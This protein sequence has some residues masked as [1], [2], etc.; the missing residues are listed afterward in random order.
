[1][2]IIG[3]VTEGNHRGRELGYPTANIALSGAPF[4]GVYAGRVV[5]HGAWYDA[6]MFADPSR[7]VLES[8]LFNF[9]DTLYGEEI[10]AV[11]VEKLRDAVHT[12]DE[13]ELRRLIAD[14]I[15]RARDVLANL[16]R[17][18]VFGTFDILHK[19]HESLFAQARARAEHPYLIVSVARD[20]SVAHIKGAPPRNNEEVRCENVAAHPLVHDVVL[21]DAEGYMPHIIAAR[22]DIIALGYDQQGEYVEHLERDVHAAGLASRIVRLEAFEPETYKTSKLHVRA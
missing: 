1:M 19:G 11:P 10:T 21:G 7:S 12:N 9:D 6:A 15:V 8:Y 16:T 20:A 22:P 4:G 14:D 13:N 18:M 3:I 2:Q 17:I 5:A